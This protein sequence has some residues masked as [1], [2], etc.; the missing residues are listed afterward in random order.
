MSTFSKTVIVSADKTFGEADAGTIQCIVSA[1]TLTIPAS[2]SD[3]FIVNDYIDIFNE[4]ASQI[5]VTAAGGVTFKKDAG[6]LM[7]Q[8]ANARIVKTDNEEWIMWG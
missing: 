8:Y 4:T 6:A 1:V 7:H 5:E 3:N 2:A